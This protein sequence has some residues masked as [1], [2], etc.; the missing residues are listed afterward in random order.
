MTNPWQTPPP[1]LGRQIRSKR[2][3]PYFVHRSCADHPFL[4]RLLLLATVAST[5][6][7]PQRRY[8]GAALPWHHHYEN[9]HP[10]SFSASSPSPVQRS[11]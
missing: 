4:K 11:I 2:R 6:S 5:G 1:V 9:P 10:L 3:R 8:T 7:A